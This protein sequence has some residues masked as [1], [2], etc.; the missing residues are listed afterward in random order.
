MEGDRFHTLLKLYFKGL[1]VRQS[2]IAQKL[3]VS[4]GLVNALILG[5]KGFGRKTAE[6]WERAFGISQ[7]WLL[8][9]GLGAMLTSERLSELSET[10]PS[11]L[12]IL[13]IASAQV[14]ATIQDD[15]ESI[16]NNARL[17]GAA[18]RV[19]SNDPEVL[20]VDFVPV[21]ATASFLEG[22][23][24]S[25]GEIEQIPIIP[26]PEERRAGT[27][28]KVFEV[29][30]ESM[31][32]TIN[33]KSQI[34]TLEIP[35]EKWHNAHGIVVAVFSDMVVV[36]RVAKN[37]LADENYILLSS[38]NPSYGEMKVPLASLR[39]L[40]KATRIISSRL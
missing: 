22:S 34:L 31:Q 19:A 24:S 20:M 38:D 32:P 30:G 26:T 25:F 10:D 35:P 5:R 9:N 7:S 15:D 33:D 29:A 4:P 12:D 27:S 21:S 18:Y 23:D 36:K 8:T 28:I 40:F 3:G 1:G 16:E 11:V 6:D 2:E 13:R 14:E 37:A 17:L 39:G